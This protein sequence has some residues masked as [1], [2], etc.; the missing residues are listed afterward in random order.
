MDSNNWRVKRDA[1]ELPTKETPNRSFQQPRPGVFNSSPSPRTGGFDQRSSPSRFSPSQPRD[2]FR[3]PIN[4][5]AAEQAIEEGRRL[6]VGNMPYEATIRDVESLFK[7]VSGIQ[8]INMSVDPMTGRNPSYCFVDFESKELAARIMGEFNG[9]DFLSRPLKVKPGVKSGSGTGRFDMRRER[10]SGDDNPFAFDRWKRLEK[11]EVMD[12]AGK[13]RRRVYVGGLP[14]FTSQADTNTQIRD[15]FQGFNVEVVSKLISA[16]E[17]KR[18]ESGNH[19]YCFVDLAT[20]GEADRAIK[21]LDGTLRWDRNIKVRWSTG[22]SGK[23]AER[24]R[25]FVGGLPEFKDQESTDAGMK[26]LFEGFQVA[27]V[28]KLFL[29]RDESKK[30]EE[31][32]HCFCFVELTNEEQTDKAKVSLDWKEMW[33]GNVRVK[34]AVSTGQSTEK[35]APSGWGS[36]R[37]RD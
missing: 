6:Y 3:R 31:G 20:S 18:E 29:P 35:A 36:S 26:E 34:P 21:S 19:N 8:G 24:R 16:H 5:A 4:D 22:S 15:L 27:T 23:L 10:Q 33:G 12:V 25:L 1:S 7:D 17:S 37:V 9:R 28:S 30:S 14:R 2:T 32:N 11:P 13:E